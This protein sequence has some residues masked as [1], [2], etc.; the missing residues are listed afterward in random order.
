MI[1][2]ILLV[3]FVILGYVGMFL[4]FKEGLKNDVWKEMGFKD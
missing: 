3:V 2:G 1:L 4:N